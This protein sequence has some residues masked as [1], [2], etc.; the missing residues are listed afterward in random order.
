M[1]EAQKI[2]PITRHR[3]EN[4]LRFRIQAESERELL[5]S[6]IFS[7]VSWLRYCETQEIMFFKKQTNRNAHETD[8]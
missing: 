1:A 6:S 7:S 2:A 5:P 4:S 3:A 8:S